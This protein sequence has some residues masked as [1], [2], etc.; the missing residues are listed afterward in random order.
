MAPKRWNE[1]RRKGTPE[2]ERENEAWVREQLL[3][4][5]L[6]ALR[7]AAGKKQVEVAEATGISQ[8][9]ISRFETREDHLISTLRKYVEALG[10]ELDVVA[11][12]GD[13]SIRL[14]GV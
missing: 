1:V 12:F 6:A 11:H 14:R 7:E 13:K 9:Q 2:Q 3:E 4:M 10:G 8:A 5:D